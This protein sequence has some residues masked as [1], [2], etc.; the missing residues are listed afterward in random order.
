MGQ[1]KRYL[2]PKQHAIQKELLSTV[3]IKATKEGCRELGTS[4]LGF[5]LS[6]M[7]HWTVEGI[8]S[9]LGEH[10][11]TYLRALADIAD[12]TKNR[13]QKEAAER[14]RRKAFDAMSAYANETPGFHQQ[15]DPRDPQP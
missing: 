12:P 5:V 14:R 13:H 10:L 1:V 4:G 15:L 7:S 3:L 8:E 9:G 11:C 6:S 2:D